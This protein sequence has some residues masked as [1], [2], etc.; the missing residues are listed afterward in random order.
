MPKGEWARDDDGDGIREVHDDT[1]EGLWPGLRD[2]L[3]PSR[4]VGKRHLYQYVA[5]FKRGCNVKR[6]TLG[7][8]RA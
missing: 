7:F 3:R 5:L 6:V 4:G 2:S 1:L 8:L